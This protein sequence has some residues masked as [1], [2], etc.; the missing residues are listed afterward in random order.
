MEK[1]K[2]KKEHEKKEGKHT[3]GSPKHI[4]EKKEKMGASCSSKMSH[5]KK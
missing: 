4:E 3:M 5:K 2:H 1:K